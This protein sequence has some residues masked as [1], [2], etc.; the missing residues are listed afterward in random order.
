MAGI[1]SRALLFSLA[2]TGIACFYTTSEQETIDCYH[3]RN[4]RLNPFI[5]NGF[6]MITASKTQGCAAANNGL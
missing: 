6:K 5:Q 4:Q 3:W 1:L 2:Q